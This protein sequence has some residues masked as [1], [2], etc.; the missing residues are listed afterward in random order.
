MCWG[1]GGLIKS[2]KE[3]AS[4]FRMWIVKAGSPPDPLGSL[5]SL[6]SQLPYVEGRHRGAKQHT[7]SLDTRMSTCITI[8]RLTTKT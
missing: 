6:L 1:R 8:P 4:I 2:L 5:A 7:Q 3:I